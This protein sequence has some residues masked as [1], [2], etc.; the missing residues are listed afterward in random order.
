VV[1]RPGSILGRAAYGL[2]LLAAMTW[3]SSCQVFRKRD[4]AEAPAPATQVEEPAPAAEPMEDEAPP[5]RPSD[6]DAEPAPAEPGETIPEIDQVSVIDTEQL[7]PRLLQEE[8]EK[9][10]TESLHRGFEEAE[11]LSTVLERRTLTA[12]QRAQVETGRGFLDDARKAMGLQDLE[13]AAVLLEKSLV[14]LRDAEVG[15]RT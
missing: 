7:G 15:S 14:L 5:V 3:L 10:S 1:N 11:K 8:D 6:D 9:I 4:T 13:R 12:E 2:L